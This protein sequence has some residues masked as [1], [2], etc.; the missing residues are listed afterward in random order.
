MDPNEFRLFMASNGPA[1]SGSPNIGDS[2][3]GG[4]YAGSIS[5]TA[6][7]VATHALIVAPRASG[8]SGTGYP[9]TTN[10]R[11]ANAIGLYESNSKV[12]GRGNMDSLIIQGI[13]NFPAANF[14]YGL[15]IGGYSDWYLPALYELAIAY[16]FLKPGA[17]ANNTAYGVNNYSVPQ[18]SSNYTASN[19]AQT[20][21]LAFRTGGS[22][23]FQAINHWSSTEV[24][25]TT[26][27]RVAFDSGGES[28]GFKTL[29][30]PVRAFRQVAL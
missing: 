23:S 25:S 19:P 6:D 13:T 12:D 16:Y 10:Y 20:T 26:S 8:A 27:N 14:C 22:E 21:A 3:Q 9:L 18:R 30:L 5:W 29:T 24:S 4:Y 17:Q 15:S 1:P 28:S 11:W 7:G 2:Y